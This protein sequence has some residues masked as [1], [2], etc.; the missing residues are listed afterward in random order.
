MFIIVVSTK[1]LYI[2]IFFLYL[3]IKSNMNIYVNQL[4]RKKNTLTPIG[5]LRYIFSNEDV[6][7]EY[8][9]HRHLNMT[10]L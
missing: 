7:F 10:N 9:Y 5:T 2:K 1:V 3:I 4:N 6:I 8:V